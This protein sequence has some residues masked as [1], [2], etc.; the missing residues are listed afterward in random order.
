MNEPTFGW[1][2]LDDIYLICPRVQA[3]IGVSEGEVDKTPFQLW[4]QIERGLH[5]QRAGNVFFA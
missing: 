3:T 2:L 1:V 5:S 4:R